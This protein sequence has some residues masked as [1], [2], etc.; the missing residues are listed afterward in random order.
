VTNHAELISIAD[1]VSETDP[2]LACRLRALAARVR[3][4]ERCLDELVEDSRLSARM[5]ES[6]AVEHL[7]RYR[8]A[9]T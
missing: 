5:A 2:A 3:S 8:R 1:L 9:R 6:V 7:S 4:Q